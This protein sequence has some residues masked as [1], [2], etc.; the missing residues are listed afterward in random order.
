MLCY[1]QLFYNLKEKFETEIGVLDRIL[2]FL[3]FSSKL[4]NRFAN[5]KD[6]RLGPRDTVFMERITRQFH[7]EFQEFDSATRN[8][9]ASGFLRDGERE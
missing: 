3:Q 2:I 7:R 9:G 5:R 8:R 6:R 4:G 1:G